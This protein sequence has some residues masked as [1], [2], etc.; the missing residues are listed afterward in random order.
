MSPVD[1]HRWV[2]NLTVGGIEK[3][4]LRVLADHAN[5]ET[6]RCWPSIETIV[7]ESRFCK[8]AVLRTIRSLSSKGIIDVDHSA[9]R[10]RN[11]YVLRIGNGASDRPFEKGNGASDA[12]EPGNQP[13]HRTNH[14]SVSKNG[15]ECFDQ[16]WKRYPRKE[17]KKKALEV[18]TRKKLESREKAT[19]IILDVIKRASEHKPWIDG[20]IPHA[21]TYLNGERWDDE[22]SPKE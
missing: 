12:P 8:N 4:V 19:P 11:V 6:L 9:G 3:G 21:S 7:R 18:W 15:R 10:N 5:R 13:D 22:I 16:F 17:G 2:A 14:M 1:R 20:Y